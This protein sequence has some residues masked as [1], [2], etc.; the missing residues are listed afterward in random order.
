MREKFT[1]ISASFPQASIRILL[2]LTTTPVTSSYIFQQPM[3]PRHVFMYL[4]MSSMIPLMKQV[5]SILCSCWRLMIQEWI[6]LMAALL[7]EGTS[8]ITTVQSTYHHNNFPDMK[9]HVV[10]QLQILYDIFV[11]TPFYIQT[12]DPWMNR[13]DNNQKQK[14][15]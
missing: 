9:V 11:Q 3:I 10:N 15:L 14:I 8:E 13:K 1:I 6:W 12:K 4:L 2:K 7:L 5:Q